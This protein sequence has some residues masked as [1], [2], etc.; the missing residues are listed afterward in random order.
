MLLTASRSEEGSRG[1][2]ASKRDRQSRGV[3]VVKG[4]EGRALTGR[5]AWDQRHGWKSCGSN[6]L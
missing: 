1:Q 3:G 6:S 2:A 5:H 4:M